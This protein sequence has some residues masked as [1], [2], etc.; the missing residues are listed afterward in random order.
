MSQSYVEIYWKKETGA[1]MKQDPS[2]GLRPQKTARKR[3]LGIL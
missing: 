3:S 1:K 2:S